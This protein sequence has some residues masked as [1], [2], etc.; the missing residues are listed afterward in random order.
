[1]RNHQFAV[2]RCGSDRNVIRLRNRDRNAVRIRARRLCSNHDLPVVATV[3]NVEMIGGVICWPAIAGQERVRPM[4]VGSGAFADAR[5][6]VSLCGTIWSPSVIISTLRSRTVQCGGSLK[7][8]GLFRVP[9]DGGF[10]WRSDGRI[11]LCNGTRGALDGSN[12]LIRSDAPEDLPAGT[13][14]RTVA[15]ATEPAEKKASSFPTSK[16]GRLGPHRVESGR[17]KFGYVIMRVEMIHAS[18]RAMT[19][20]R[21]AAS[22]RQPAPSPS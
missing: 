1:V 21:A 11:H 9:V 5:F 12:H 8:T 20:D 7:G 13:G 4:N 15:D 10:P 2:L 19:W 22:A 6:K 14:R 17:M 16:S 18:W 3:V